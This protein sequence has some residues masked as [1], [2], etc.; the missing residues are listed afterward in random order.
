MPRGQRTL[1]P[2][3]SSWMELQ[4]FDEIHLFS[5]ASTW[6]PVNVGMS[7]SDSEE[8]VSRSPNSTTGS[9]ASSAC[10]SGDE[11][12][13]EETIVAP[14]KPQ[15]T[16]LPRDWREVARKRV[17]LCPAVELF[18]AM[19]ESVQLF[20]CR[21]SE[22]YRATHLIRTINTPILD[23]DIPLDQGSEA[24]IQLTPCTLDKL[25]EGITAFTDRRAFR[26][27]LHAR[28]VIIDSA[29]CSLVCFFLGGGLTA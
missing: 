5:I 11:S 6:I 14:Q 24:D 25:D 10:D 29:P 12:G 3:D 19:T 8:Y 21:S 7:E 2:G 28:I 13:G 1:P 17:E 27:R 9:G 15:F 18:N 26:S 4:E 16:Q 23:S 20:D 22:L